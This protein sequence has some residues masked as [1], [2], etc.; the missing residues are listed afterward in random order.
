MH[1]KN[2]DSLEDVDHVS[3]SGDVENCVLK[4]RDNLDLR[5]PCLAPED[6]IQ[7]C[8]DYVLELLRHCERNGT[9][10]SLAAR[11]VQGQMD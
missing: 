10:G 4:C 5:H 1:R 2:Q 6:P 7:M 9:H 8:L 11:L 3:F